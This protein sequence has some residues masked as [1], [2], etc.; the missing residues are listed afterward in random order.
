MPKGSSGPAHTCG[1]SQSAIP[2]SSLS[3]LFTTPTCVQPSSFLDTSLSSVRPVS[4]YSLVVNSLTGLASF[5][6]SNP[7]R[8]VIRLLFVTCSTAPAAPPDLPRPTLHL[9]LDPAPRHFTTPFTLFPLQP[10]W[11]IRYHLTSSSIFAFGLLLF[12]I[13][14]FQDLFGAN[15][16]LKP[17]WVLPPINPHPY[18][19]PPRS[20]D[21][22]N[23]AFEYNNQYRNIQHPKQPP[24]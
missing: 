12:A 2:S 20:L 14:R 3:S 22:F 7:P 24:T 15:T 11:Y 16:T 1:Q 18:A 8:L 19:P 21:P 13:H 6:S 5:D 10:N 17:G 9:H 23:P 4:A